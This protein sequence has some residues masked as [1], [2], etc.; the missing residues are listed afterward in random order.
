MWSVGCGSRPQLQLILRKHPCKKPT[1]EIHPI[2]KYF[3][4]GEPHL[5]DRKS[6]VQKVGKTSP[7]KCM[8]WAQLDMGRP[9]RSLL[10]E[11]SS[12]TVHYKDSCQSYRAWLVVCRKRYQHGFHSDKSPGLQRLV[13]V[14]VWWEIVSDTRARQRMHWLDSGLCLVGCICIK[15]KSTSDYIHAYGILRTPMLWAGTTVVPVY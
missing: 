4:S 15:W 11:G 13:V 12:C 2:K 7:V 5:H 9:V 14:C 10:S 8:I 3:L 6:E 1:L